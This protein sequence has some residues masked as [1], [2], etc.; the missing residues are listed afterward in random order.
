MPLVISL[1]SVPRS[2]ENLCQLS[3]YE[4]LFNCILAKTWNY[5]LIAN[6]IGKKWYSFVLL[7]FFFWITSLM[8]YFFI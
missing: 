7:W 6:F 4:W 8:E 5:F 2:P 3:V 1:G